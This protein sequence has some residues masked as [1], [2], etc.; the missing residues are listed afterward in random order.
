MTTIGFAMIR[1]LTALLFL[2]LA[3]PAWALPPFLDGNA[4]RRLEFDI[5]RHGETIGIHSLAFSNRAGTVEVEFRVN[6]LVTLLSI[7][8]YRYEQ[9]GTEVWEGDTLKSLVA[10]S[11]DNGTVHSVRAERHGAR[12]RVVTNRETLDIAEMPTMT[13]WRAI[14]P[15]VTQAIDPT[16]GKPSPV[17]A[18]DKGWETITVR[19]AP[20]RAHRWAWDGEMKRQLWYD[21]SGALVQ[22]HV[23]GSDGSDIYYVLR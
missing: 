23:T 17:F 7:P 8:V 3:A 16:D 4:S 21:E 18:T 1:L 9:H 2:L 12:I 19:G 20:I 15:H 13:L 10:K 6:V 11:N 22:M 5:V 14:P